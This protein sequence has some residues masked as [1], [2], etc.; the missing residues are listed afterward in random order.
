MTNIVSNKVGTHIQNVLALNNAIKKKRNL[1][2]LAFLREGILGGLTGT[3][4][5]SAQA[6]SWGKSWLFLKIV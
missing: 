2:F 6:A 4:G 3:I 5:R 1:H